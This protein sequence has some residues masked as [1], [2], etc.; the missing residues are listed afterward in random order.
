MFF[1]GQRHL[2]KDAGFCDTGRGV[3]QVIFADQQ[4]LKRR[5]DQ[6]QLLNHMIHEVCAESPQLCQW[7]SM[8]AQADRDHPTGAQGRRGSVPWVAVTHLGMLGMDFHGGKSPT[9]FFQR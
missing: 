9:V 6:T 4:A 7:D 1:H 5:I 8:S 3:L 2:T